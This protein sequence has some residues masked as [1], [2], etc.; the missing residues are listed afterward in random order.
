M[1]RK[2]VFQ[3]RKDKKRQKSQQN[4]IY[5]LSEKIIISKPIEKYFGKQRARGGR[6]EN[7][8]LPTQCSSTSSTEIN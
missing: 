2:Q 7:P 4:N 3:H 6:N 8:N 1:P 5:F